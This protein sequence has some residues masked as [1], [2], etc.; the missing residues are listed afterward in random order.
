VSGYSVA[1]KVILV[2]GG[3]SGIGEATARRLAAAGAH[4]MLAG[5][6]Q[7]LGEAIAA[8]LRQAGHQADFLAADMTVDCDA[9]RLVD[10]V[11][12]MHGRLDGAVNTA[13]SFD[14]AGPLTEL[15]VKAWRTELDTN[16]T[17]VFLGLKY[18]LRAMLQ[19][20]VQGS[21]VNNAAVGGTSGFAGMSAYCAA[22]HGVIGLTRSAALEVA[23]RGV[24]IN[25]L[26]IGTVDT[27]MLRKGQ[28]L[29][30]SDPLPSAKP[31]PA[32]RIASAGEIAGFTQFLLS[33]DAGYITGAALPID[34]GLSAQC[35]PAR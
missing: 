8:D 3:T 16:L 23:D 35:L 12:S 34:G 20:G 25:A 9:E 32:G 30:P 15:D 33:D 2:C 17:S 26:V 27:P 21:V 18:Q 22:K 1:D 29:G 28:G 14:A 10:R 13:G 11:M 6:R 24:R 19:A 4:V 31:V 5:R 7:A